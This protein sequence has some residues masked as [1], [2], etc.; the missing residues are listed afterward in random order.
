MDVRGVQNTYGIFYLLLRV[1]FLDDGHY[2]PPS[3]TET[4]TESN[5]DLRKKIIITAR[6]FSH[7]STCDCSTLAIYFQAIIT[8]CHFDR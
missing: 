8:V 6:A 2:L 5:S 1:N 4:G 7:P 3:S